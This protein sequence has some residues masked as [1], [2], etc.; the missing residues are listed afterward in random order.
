[1]GRLEAIYARRAELLADADE[2]RKDIA[3]YIQN[4]FHPGA[5]TG[6]GISLIRSLA[7]SG[8]VLWLFWPGRRRRGLFALSLALA[9]YIFRRRQGG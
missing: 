6:Y 4:V 7:A 5:C 3:T 1:M 8:G 2:Q 9:T